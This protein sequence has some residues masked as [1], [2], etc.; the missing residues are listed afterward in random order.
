MRNNVILNCSQDVGIYLNRSADTHIYNNLLYNNL[1]ID[2]RFETSTASITNNLIAGRVRARD[3]GSYEEHNN[4]IDERC[5]GSPRNSCS[6]H[7]FY[8]SPANADLRLKDLDNP[9]WNTGV[10]IDAVTDDVCGHG[11]GEVTDIGPIQYSAGLDCLQ[12]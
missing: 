6:F 8:A 11:R 1:G 12:P 4:L 10:P 3:G 9:I 7:S 5:F 2:V